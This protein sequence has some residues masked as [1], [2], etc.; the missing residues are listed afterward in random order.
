MRCLCCNRNLS[1]YESTLKSLTTGDYMDTCVK[2]LKDLDIAV[3][4]NGKA[5]T[6]VPMEDDDLYEET[7]EEPDEELD[8]ADL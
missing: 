5:T 8:D 1:D 6:E 2:C 3:V 4:G 7:Y